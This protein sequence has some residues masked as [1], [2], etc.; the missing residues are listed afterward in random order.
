MSE[1]PDKPEV[2]PPPDSDSAV[3]GESSRLL[4]AAEARRKESSTSRLDEDTKNELPGGVRGAF[5]SDAGGAQW[6][7]KLPINM[8]T[9]ELPGDVPRWRV[10]IHGL[11]PAVEPLGLDI[12]GDAIVGRGR[13]GT[14]PVDLD[15]DL[16]GALEQGISRRHAM[17]RPTANHLY[18]IDLGSTNGTMHNGLPLGPGIA[19]SLKHNDTL[20]LGRLSFTIKIIDGPPLHTKAPPEPKPATSELD[21]TKPL[22][23]DHPT[24]A[25][26]QPGTLR[27]ITDADIQAYLTQQKRTDTVKLEDEKP[28]A[29][30]SGTG[31]LT[32]KKD[33]AKASKEKKDEK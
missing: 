9:A 32:E 33:E 6:Y 25:P 27:A 29:G 2:S 10:E 22:G 23:N 21:K 15:L 20:T 24:R 18:V 17:L 19:R 8:G 3:A 5:G 30:V 28:A 1:R 14:E 7:R 26:T 4:Q 11:G 12:I 13:V 16:Y 31:P